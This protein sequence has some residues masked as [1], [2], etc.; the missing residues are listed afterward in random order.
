MIGWSLNLMIGHHTI[1]S[2]GHEEKWCY[3]KRRR[4]REIIILNSGSSGRNFLLFSLSLSF[5]LLFYDYYLQSMTE[6]PSDHDDDDDDSFI[7][8]LQFIQA[9]IRKGTIFLVMSCGI[10]MSII[11]IRLL[12][13]ISTLTTYL[14]DA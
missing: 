2:F 9:N 10:M 4:K 8:H 6:D 11:L 13:L 5:S 7:H 14:I 12:L 3:K 1:I